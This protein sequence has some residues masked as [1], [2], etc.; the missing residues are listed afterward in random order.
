MVNRRELLWSLAMVTSVACSAPPSPTVPRPK[1]KVESTPTP[2]PLPTPNPCG[3]PGFTS[4]IRA[5]GP[6]KPAGYEEMILFKNRFTPH[7]KTNIDRTFWQIL[8][9]QTA[10]QTVKGV[11]VRQ[12]P[13]TRRVVGREGVA[14]TIPQ[15]MTS[16]TYDIE[17]ENRDP[18]RIHMTLALLRDRDNG[19]VTEE[20]LVFFFD[21]K[22][23]GFGNERN[24]RGQGYKI[25]PEM[26]KDILNRV[27][28]D[29]PTPD[30]LKADPRSNFI[31]S[32]KHF[33]GGERRCMLSSIGRAQLRT[34]YSV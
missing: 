2:L 18:R 4:E 9:K 22:V 13:W 15:T 23:M 33:E 14:A 12:S 10:C 31:T 6:I 5:G 26:W 25:D 7:F 11:A 34:I 1:Q 19:G 17:T 27:L 28:V 20:D 32:T 29:P 21:L 16:F 30:S 24:N 8:A 3:A